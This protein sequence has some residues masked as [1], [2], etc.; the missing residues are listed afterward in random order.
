MSRT[1]TLKAT[2]TLFNGFL[3]EQKYNVSAGVLYALILSLPFILL[4]VSYFILI[5]SVILSFS[6]IKNNLGKM[7]TFFWPNCLILN[8]IGTTF[9]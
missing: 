8:G 1:L 4:E 2:L 7:V 5:E 9:N 3:H 6:G